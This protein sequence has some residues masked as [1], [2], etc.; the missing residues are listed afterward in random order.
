MAV[1]SSDVRARVRRHESIDG[2]VPA[3]V[4]RLVA[5]LGL[6]LDPVSPSRVP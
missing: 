4:A 1:S 2:L 3:G 6:Y 5:E